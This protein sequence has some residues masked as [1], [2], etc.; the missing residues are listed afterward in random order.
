MGGEAGQE[1]GDGRGTGEKWR[2]SLEWGWEPEFLTNASSDSEGG[3]I[4]DLQ[5]ERAQEQSCPR[6][7]Y[8]YRTIEL[9]R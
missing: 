9:T 7:K 4:Q 6:S 8:K 3:Q 5:A 2:L 1:E